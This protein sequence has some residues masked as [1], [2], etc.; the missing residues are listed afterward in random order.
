MSTPQPDSSYPSNDDDVDAESGNSLNEE[1]KLSASTARTA[2][3]GEKKHIAKPFSDFSV[4]PTA[5]HPEEDAKTGGDSDQGIS[6]TLRNLVSEDGR[7]ATASS[8]ADDENKPYSPVPASNN[9]KQAL[10][11]DSICKNRTKQVFKDAGE[12]SEGIVAIEAW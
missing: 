7:P 12:Q 11:I 5:S 2:V 4:K 9:F 1:N 8:K 10:E 3:I 6:Q